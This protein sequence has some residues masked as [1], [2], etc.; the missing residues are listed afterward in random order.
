MTVLIALSGMACAAGLLLANPRR[1]TSTVDAT[2]MGWSPYRAAVASAVLVVVFAIGAAGVVGIRSG[3][4]AGLQ[5]GILALLWGPWFVPAML[6]SSVLGSYAG[7]RD[8]NLL[9]W[10]RRMR[11]L[12]ATGLPINAAAVE[13]SMAV[14]GRGFTPAQGRISSALS[15]GHDPLGV[16]LDTLAGSSAEP[17]LRS[18]IAAERA[19]AASTGLLDRT[20]AR[21]VRTFEA[22]RRAS[23]T[24]VSRMVG[25]AATMSTVVAGVIALLSVLSGL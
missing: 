17:L 23:I 21:T 18:V 2:A 15:A 24:S 3:T 16:I 11:L 14:R 13:A 1:S 25:G 5:A 7:E 4:Q 9:E 6:R 8:M 12:A 10:F 20:L 19:G 22:D